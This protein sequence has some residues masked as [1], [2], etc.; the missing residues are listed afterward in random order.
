LSIVERTLGSSP[1]F[2]FQHG[3]P[4][5]GGPAAVAAVLNLLQGPLE[6][7][8]LDRTNEQ[9]AELA[10]RIRNL[11]FVFEDLRAVDDRALQRLLR[12]VDTKLLAVA[13]KGASAELRQRVISQMSQ[14]AAAALNDEME[15]LG[16]T[17]MREVEAAQAGVITQARALEAAGE[18]VLLGSHDDAVVV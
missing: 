5:A 10:E 15:L 12:D 4:S 17:R 3:V 1:D 18:L 13:L 7:A 6:K 11:M 8:L 16:P 2:D 14:R 9:D